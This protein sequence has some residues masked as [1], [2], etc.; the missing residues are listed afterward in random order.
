M[1]LGGM[2]NVF[3]Q[4]TPRQ[5]KWVDALYRANTEST[6]LN[7]MAQTLMALADEEIAAAKHEAYHAAKAV[8][9]GN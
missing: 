4:G 6:S 3:A 2:D 8:N 9:A 5:M 7:Q 1:N